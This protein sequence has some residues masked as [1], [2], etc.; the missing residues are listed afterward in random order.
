M[1]A[2]KEARVGGGRAR[3]TKIPISRKEREKWGSRVGS[4]YPHHPG[5]SLFC[6]PR[7]FL[8][9][10]FHDILNADYRGTIHSGH[11]EAYPVGLQG[12]GGVTVP[13]SEVFALQRAS[14]ARGGHGGGA[15]PAHAGHQG[16]A[17]RGTATD[18]GTGQSDAR[19][20]SQR[21]GTD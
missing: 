14:R 19:S 16:N 2:G 5:R 11:E 8:Y 13:D 9:I 1:E 20:T 6:H 15:V 3:A 17:G 10:S 21:G 12:S 7:R 4:P 18:P